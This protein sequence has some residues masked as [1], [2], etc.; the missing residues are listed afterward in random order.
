MA[1]D[2]AKFDN[3]FMSITQQCE[4][5]IQEVLYF[6]FIFVS[7]KSVLSLSVGPRRGYH[8]LARLFPL[9]KRSLSET[10]VSMARCIPTHHFTV[11]MRQ[12]E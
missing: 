2:Y 6:L 8:S 9:E 4:G 5:G 10:V 12:Q 7:D 11:L 3:H 1:G